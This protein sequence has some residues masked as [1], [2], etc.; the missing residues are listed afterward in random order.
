MAKTITLVG[1][2]K[3]PGHE[4]KRPERNHNAVS[5]FRRENF[6]RFFQLVIPL[7]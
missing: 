4:G 3:L 1:V 6:K 5:G 2:K 7:K